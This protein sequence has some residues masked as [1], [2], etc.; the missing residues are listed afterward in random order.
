[1]GSSRETSIIA[2]SA[3]SAFILRLF[4]KLGCARSVDRPD[5]NSVRRDSDV[6]LRFAGSDFDFT[7]GNYS[8]PRSLDGNLAKRQKGDSRSVDENDYRKR[9]HNGCAYPKLVGTVFR[10]RNESTESGTKRPFV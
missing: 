3:I 1:M 6:R 5:R 8:K 9:Q 2:G 10:Q 4:S 7:T